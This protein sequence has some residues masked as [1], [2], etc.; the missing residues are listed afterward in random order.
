MRRFPEHFI[1]AKRRGQDWEF[2][3]TISWV[4]GW[5]L[6]QA[7][8]ISAVEKKTETV[9]TALVE[10]DANAV[11]IPGLELAVLAGSRTEKVQLS[12]LTVPLSSS[13]V[14]CVQPSEIS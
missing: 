2:T 6:N 12:A 1:E 10:I 9:I 4:S 14:V 11:S 8:N 3:G 5:G 13:P 7:L